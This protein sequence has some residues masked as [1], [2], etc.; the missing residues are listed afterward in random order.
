MSRAFLQPDDLRD[1][2]AE[3]FGTDRRLVSLDRLT[4]GSKKGVYR[5]GLAGGGTVVAYAW[6]AAENFWPAR[7]DAPDDPLGDASGLDLFRAAYDRLA[8]A[9][10][11]TP[12]LLHAT[13]DPDLAVVQDVR[14]GTLEDLLARDPAAA[15]VPLA[16]LRET[17]E[18][19]RVAAGPRVGAQLAA[20][21]GKVGRPDRTG[22]TCPEIVVD[23]ARRDV[24]EAAAR[25]PRIAAVRG[26]LAALLRADLPARTG[27]AL[28]HGELGPD[29]VLLDDAGEPVLVDIEGVMSFDVEWEHAFLEIRFGDHYP[30]LAVDGLDLDR[31]RLYRLALHLSLVAGPLRLADGDFPEAAFMREIA[32]HHT[33]LALA[34]AS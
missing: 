34:Y 26:R 25:V 30:A 1:L 8:A 4:G 16:A 21:V 29:H 10:V 23:R 12:R 5:V 31:M 2:V 22:R 28:V 17:L 7:G 32:E 11:R 6:A 27:H 33:G 9:G 20:E 19:M 13:R 3:E 24:A 14:G 18:R 15:A